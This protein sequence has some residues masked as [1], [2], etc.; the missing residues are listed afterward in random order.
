MSLGVPEINQILAATEIVN[1]NGRDP[2]NADQAIIPLS[3][4]PTSAGRLR[5]ITLRGFT[6]TPTT[7]MERVTIVFQL[8]AT[9]VSNML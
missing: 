9:W 4:F 8:N 7:L 2:G 6:Y 5:M 1:L 3:T